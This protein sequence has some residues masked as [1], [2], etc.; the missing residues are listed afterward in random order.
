M[1]FVSPKKVWQILFEGTTS[2]LH[3]MGMR[4]RSLSFVICVVTSEEKGFGV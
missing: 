2:Q 1:G 4:H 3:C